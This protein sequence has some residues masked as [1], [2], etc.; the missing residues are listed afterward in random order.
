MKNKMLIIAVLAVL[1]LSAS[2]FV[3]GSSGWAATDQSPIVNI[4]LSKTTVTDAIKAL[5]AGTGLN[6]LLSGD[7]DSKI[8]ALRLK[9]VSLDSALKTIAQVAGF[10]YTVENGVYVITQQR[11]EASAAP[12]QETP[13]PRSAP[14][15]QP[16]E[17][18]VQLPQVQEAAGL[19]AQTDN[20]Q[21]Y[22]DMQPPPGYY[23]QY[24]PQPYPYYDPYGPYMPPAYHVG[25]VTVLGRWPATTFG[26]SG[27]YTLSPS[28]LAWPY[29]GY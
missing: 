21:A 8:I 17:D 9:G 24:G 16:A 20:P 4:E 26:G 7:L 27:T 6:Y 1:V 19:P 15:A 5:F 11:A 22:P 13:S 3:G 14:V 23:G 12:K 28:P 10:T 18:V 29:N 2:G 25:Q